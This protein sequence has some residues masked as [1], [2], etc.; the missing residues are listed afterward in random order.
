[1][2]V[3]Q[4]QSD[5]KNK[6][7]GRQQHGIYP[8][9]EPQFPQKSWGHSAPLLQC[10]QVA[11]FPQTCEE[12]GSLISLP[13]TAGITSSTIWLIQMGECLENW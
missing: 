13:L 4:A 3:F 11:T 6:S 2:P 7:A 1:M 10:K 9:S 8:C 12:R 5:L